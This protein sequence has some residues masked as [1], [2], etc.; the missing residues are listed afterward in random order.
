MGPVTPAAFNRVIRDRL[1]EIRRRLA[2][3]GKE[4]ARGDRLSNFKVAAAFQGVTP[5]RALMGM[6]AKHLVS[7]ADLVG[8]GER[9]VVHPPQVWDEKIGDAIAYL[10]LL[11]ALRIEEAGCGHLREH[12]GACPGSDRHG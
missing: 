8:D 7:I 3:K 11:D 4:Y 5:E 12:V 6:L 10:V 2:A 1:Q 9:G